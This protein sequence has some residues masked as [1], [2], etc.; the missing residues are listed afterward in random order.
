[1]RSIRSVGEP[2]KP[3]FSLGKLALGAVASLA[4][5]GG[6]QAADLPVKARAVQYVKICSLYG[7]GYYYIPGTDTWHGFTKR[8]IAGVRKS[9]I[10]NYVSPEWRDTYE[11]A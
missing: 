2:G 4:V 5:I 11:L 10:I 6:A 7:A 9:I 1:M 3:L 8:P